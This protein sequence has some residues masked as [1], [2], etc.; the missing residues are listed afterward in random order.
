MSSNPHLRN[1]KNCLNCGARVE[2]RFCTRCGQENVEIKESFGHLIGHFFSDLTHYDSKF[3][4]TIKDLLF[5]PGFLTNEYLAGRRANYLHPVRMYVF[6]SFLYFLVSLSFN[7]NEH[8]SEEAIAQIAAQ[9]TRRQIADSLN[10][11]LPAGNANAAENK[12]KDSLIRQMR[13]KVGPDSL[14]DKNITILFDLKYNDLVAFDSVQQKL[15]EQRREKG[16]KPWLYR[17]WQNTIDMYGRKGANMLVRNRTAHVIPKM[18][19]ILLPL[20]ALLLEIFYNR[21]KYFYSDHVIFSLHFH[22]AVFLIFLF[23]AIISLLFPTLARDARNVEILL[24]AIYLALALKRTYGQSTIR[25][26]VKTIALTILYSIF[27]LAGYVILI[28]SALL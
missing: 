28:I 19:F 27:I 8:R 7:D 21:K 4:V 15:P 1:E 25:T 12:M 14:P 11:L 18:M 24:A 5:K 16:L 13:A 3:F 22:T 6:V 2:E 20:F 9:D 10:S 23:F 26:I 17:H